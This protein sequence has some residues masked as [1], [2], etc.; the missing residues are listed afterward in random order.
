MSASYQEKIL[1]RYY[2]GMIIK[3]RTRKPDRMCIDASVK[4]AYG[5]GFTMKMK[6]RN[7]SGG[8]H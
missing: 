1:R 5:I 8:G 6:G 2:S 4:A 7:I 3:H